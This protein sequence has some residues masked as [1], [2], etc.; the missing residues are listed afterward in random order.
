MTVNSQNFASQN[1]IS[2]IL[3]GLILN[4]CAQV[5]VADKG[6][7]YDKAIANFTHRHILLNAVRGSK[8]RPMNFTAISS[9]KGNASTTG[10]I[11]TSLPFGFG[12][13]GAFNVNPRI[14]G[15]DGLNF[16]LTT[17]RSQDFYNAII[18]DISPS[19]YQFYDESGWPN[20]LL[21]MIFINEILLNEGVD[22]AIHDAFDELCEGENKGLCGVVNDDLAWLE[23][24]CV[25]EDED[26]EFD[27]RSYFNS[28]RS[29]CSYR[30]YQTIIRKWRILKISF[31]TRTSSGEKTIKIKSYYR[32][33]NDKGQPAGN[34]NK[35]VRVKEPTR[36][37]QLVLRLTEIP[38]ILKKRPK[39]KKLMSIKEFGQVRL[40][41]PQSMIF[42][43]G[44]LVAA[45]TL[46]ENR[47]TPTILI[48]RGRDRWA[49]VNLF[50]VVRGGAPGRSALSVVDEDG[51]RYSLVRPE[52][53]A[54]D[55]ARSLQTLALINQIFGQI[56][57]RKDL[58][59]SAN[60]PVV[61]TP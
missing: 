42:Y 25:P 21:D 4:G 22:K 47:Y 43:L 12:S 8:R 36:K 26:L 48:G 7:E 20:E 15:T 37:S 59:V 51:E 55:E 18:N 10:G 5:F 3:F 16:D 39:Y 17:L 30:M 23:S 2:I 31:G 52:H 13:N 19:T 57:K 24:N 33:F 1:W 54:T 6:I 40:R 41:S 60:I 46:G 11:T 34:P 32:V 50:E 9:V 27:N 49:H 58:P 29:Q 61:V 38:K 35:E 56:I 44:E 45:Q 28:A 53:G 14:S